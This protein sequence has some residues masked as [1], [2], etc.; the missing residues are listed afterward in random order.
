MQQPL[1]HLEPNASICDS[2]RPWDCSGE[3]T[4][5]GNR[6]CQLQGKRTNQAVNT[7]PSISNEILSIALPSAEKRRLTRFS[8]C[9][10]QEFQKAESHYDK[11]PL[12]FTAHCT[13]TDSVRFMTRTLIRSLVIAHFVQP[14][15]WLWLHREGSTF[16]QAEL[17]TEVRIKWSGPMVVAICLSLLGEAPGALG[18]MWLSSTS[19]LLTS[20]LPPPALPLHSKPARLRTHTHTHTH[21]HHEALLK[22]VKLSAVGLF[23]WSDP[24]ADLNP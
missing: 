8:S 11:Q 10:H 20:V 2:G 7:W 3:G 16:S 9:L 23:S 14:G 12:T 4:S 22:S 1:K 13:H 19:Y 18:S 21:T 17:E 15:T 5:R 24:K 6:P